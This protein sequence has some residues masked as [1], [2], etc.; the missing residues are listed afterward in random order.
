MQQF[1]VGKHD[2][3]FIGEYDNPIGNIVHDTDY[4]YINGNKAI[5]VK[6]C[7]I[8]G[9]NI[10]ELQSEPERPYYITA[11]H[12]PAKLKRLI[13]DSYLLFKDY[14]NTT[15]TLSQ[16]LYETSLNILTFEYDV[17]RYTVDVNKLY[18][19]GVHIDEYNV[20]TL[21]DIEKNASYVLSNK[22]ETITMINLKFSLI[23][24]QIIV[25]ND[26]A[27]CCI[28]DCLDII[29]NHNEVD[30]IVINRKYRNTETFLL[31]LKYD[32]PIVLK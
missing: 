13:V 28:K 25:G 15:Y 10:S 14:N 6:D 20:T 3:V 27:H 4:V 9:K 19:N 31:L 18:I 8:N 7:H 12:I 1:R 26:G 21:E 5:L 29:I 11:K 2:M 32:I 16:L 23:N 24:K 30:T 17:F 22:P